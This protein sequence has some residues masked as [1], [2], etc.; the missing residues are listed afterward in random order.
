MS[1]A[2]RLPPQDSIGPDPL[3]AALGRIR[4]RAWEPIAFKLSLAGPLPDR[5]RAHPKNLRAGNLEI[6]EEIHK[7]R[8]ALAGEVLE[9]PAGRVWTAQMP[10]S[11]RFREE[12][13]SFTWLRHLGAIDRLVP[14]G[15]VEVR[16]AARALTE[17][18]IEAHGAF[19]RSAW[20]APIVGRRIFSWLS[21]ARLLSDGADLLWRT[22]FHQSLAQQARYLS[23]VMELAPRGLPRLNAVTGVVLGCLS[24]GDGGPRRARA[25]QLLNDE[26]STQ[27]L[28]DGG[29]ASRSPALQLEILADLLTLAEGFRQSNTP[30][31]RAL[32]ETI[33]RMM[34]MLQFFH[35][36]SGRLAAFHGAGCEAPETVLAVLG[37]QPAPS[38]R[39]SHAPQ[40]GFD[41]MSAG[42]TLVLV[43]C[44]PAP[45]LQ[46]AG[47]AHAGAFAFELASK[48]Q[49]IVVNCGRSAADDAQARVFRTPAAHSTLSFVGTPARTATTREKALTARLAGGPREVEVVRG[50]APGA[51]RPVKY[52]AAPPPGEDSGGTWL[53]LAHNGYGEELGRRHVRRFYLDERGADLRGEDRIEPIAEAPM[54]P[55]VSYRLRFHLHPGVEAQL[56]EGRVRLALPSGELWQFRHRGGELVLAESIFNGPGG[57]RATKQIVIKGEA[58]LEA[59]SISWAFRREGAA[60]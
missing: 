25:V 3:T 20:S 8:F 41:C 52:L 14:A 43:D 21:E 44:G 15:V 48:G 27:I 53:E 50:E 40:S 13:E 38:R 54:V 49:P 9:A 42:E 32:E 26:L 11:V 12:L 1:I 31:P 28:A 36:G 2:H 29:H 33:A 18:W 23:S 60:E 39:P 24:L 58:A 47:T 7:G 17:S 55:A 51:E 56:E 30:S 5:L 37:P 35:V 22:K 34:P 16:E 45:P 10:P 4:A 59:I 57:A 6:G 19:T 46:F